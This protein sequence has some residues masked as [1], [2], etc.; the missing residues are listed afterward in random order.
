MLSLSSLWGSTSCIRFVAT[1]VSHYLAMYQSISSVWGMIIRLFQVWLEVTN[2]NNCYCG[3]MSFMQ[4]SSGQFSLWWLRIR[5]T[6]ATIR[7]IVL[8]LFSS[9]LGQSK[10]IAMEIEAAEGRTTPKP[11]D[12]TFQPSYS[13]AV[14]KSCSHLKCEDSSSAYIRDKKWPEL[15]PV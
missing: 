13:G 15:S 4:F 12:I 1:T 9:D 10:L 14:S 5:I 6:Q 2:N 11:R 7:I 8:V 3:F